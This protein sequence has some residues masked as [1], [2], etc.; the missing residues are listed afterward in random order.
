MRAIVLILLVVFMLVLVFVCVYDDAHKRTLPLYI[1][2]P[3][4][5][6]TKLGGSK[7]REK[8]LFV[9][10]NE[11]RRRRRSRPGP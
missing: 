5:S 8:D 7:K 3:G 9:A 6:K 11:H 1:V 10:A 4:R 2:S